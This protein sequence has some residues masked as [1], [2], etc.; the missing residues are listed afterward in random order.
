MMMLGLEQSLLQLLIV[1][2]IRKGIDMLQEEKEALIFFI[3]NSVN[4]MF[5]EKEIEYLTKLIENDIN[6]N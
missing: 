2:D 6:G 4:N 1:L 3:E 5:D